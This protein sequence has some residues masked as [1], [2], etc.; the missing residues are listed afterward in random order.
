MPTDSMKFA[1]LFVLHAISCVTHSVSFVL[2]L[3]TYVTVDL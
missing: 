2:P 3:T 1:A